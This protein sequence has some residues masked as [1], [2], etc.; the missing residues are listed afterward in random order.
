MKNETLNQTESHTVG[1]RESTIRKERDGDEE[2]Q[3]Q[4]IVDHAQTQVQWREDVGKNHQRWP[5]MSHT[6]LPPHHS[7]ASRT[8]CVQLAYVLGGKKER[9][10]QKLPNS[11]IIVMIDYAESMKESARPATITIRGVISFLTR[12]GSF[13]TQQV[14][15]R[16]VLIRPID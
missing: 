2:Q 1:E 4:K 16:K 9:N 14:L 11:K 3:Q 15:M 10:A 8:H 7:L 12:S 6:C 13:I 5:C